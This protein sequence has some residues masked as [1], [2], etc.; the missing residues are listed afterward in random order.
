MSHNI[1]DLLRAARLARSA[2]KAD[3]EEQRR[4]FAYGNTAIENELITRTMVNEQAD[5]LDRE[6]H[7]RGQSGPTV[8]EGC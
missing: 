8:H 2:T 7:E 6:A 5:R 3:R 4:S 1:A